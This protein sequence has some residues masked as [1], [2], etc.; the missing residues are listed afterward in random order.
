MSLLEQCHG[1]QVHRC[2]N[3]RRMP[4]VRRGRRRPHADPLLARR[5]DLH[6]Q[7]GGHRPRRQYYSAMIC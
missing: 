2:C 1:A 3:T 5:R 7:A 6:P 4:P